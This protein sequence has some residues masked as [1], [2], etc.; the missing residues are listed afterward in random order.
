MGLFVVPIFGVEVFKPALELEVQPVNF[1]A[2]LVGLPIVALVPLSSPVTVTV[3][4]GFEISITLLYLPLVGAFVPFV[5][6]FNV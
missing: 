2:L 4:V 3:L 1:C 6:P 5:P